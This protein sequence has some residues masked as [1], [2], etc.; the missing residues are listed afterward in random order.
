MIAGIAGTLLFIGFLLLFIGIFYNRFKREVK[1]Y[2]EK[3]ER[4]K[5]IG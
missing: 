5:W 2:I 1:E 4:K 3:K